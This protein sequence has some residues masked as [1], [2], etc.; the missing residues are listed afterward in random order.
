[1]Q[2]ACGCETVRRGLKLENCFSDGSFHAEAGKRKISVFIPVYEGSDL[3]GPLLERLVNDEYVDKEIFV[4]VDKPN[5]E[6]F[7]IVKRY[8]GKVHFLLS[9][10]RKGKVEA[11]NNAVAISSGEILVF[12][13]ADVKIGNMEGFLETV[14]E[15]MADT[16]ILD[17]KKK[18]LRDSFISRMVNY[19]YAGSN[20]ASYLY[21]KLVGKCFGVGGTAFAI[22]RNVF[23]EVGGFSR[24]ISEDL[25]LAVKILLK[26]RKFK[27][28]EK[29]EVYTKAPSNWKSWLKQRKRWGIGT[30]LWIKGYWRKLVRY[31]AKYPHVALPCAIV[32]FPTV[33]P[34]LFSYI[35][36]AFLK[37]QLQNLVPSVLAAQLSFP[38]PQVIP[39]SLLSIIFTGLTNFFLGF[40]AFSFVF[41]AVSRRFDFR[42]NF[43]EF[44]VYYF[45]YQPIAALV[46][47]VGILRAFIFQNHELDWKV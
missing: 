4:A 21:S 40:L 38:L 18:I 26:N 47:F 32:L 9:N 16:D 10:E 7:E 3:L 2:L 6:F 1:M 45:V 34:L 17:F 43:A 15:E 41:Y 24:V 44:L 11:L 25:D 39:D 28:T 8:N 30:G 37:V 27:Y 13:D 42:F 35:C 12:L 5:R 33:I 23:K 22:R 31:I 14:V 36:S 19:E 46:L 29:V 20:F